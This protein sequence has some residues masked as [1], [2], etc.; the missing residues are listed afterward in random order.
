[1]R[2][3]FEPPEFPDFRRLSIVIKLCDHWDLRGSGT[4]LPTFL[5]P[6]TTVRESGKSAELELPATGQ[7]VLVTLGINRIIEQESL[8]VF[9]Y[10]SKD[11]SEWG[12][13][14]LLR[15]PQ[16]FYCGT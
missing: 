11:G 8:D 4:M 6:E 16:K 3:G 14:P 13:K 12:S 2:I 15:F 9:I 5:V 10:G 7:S 1:M